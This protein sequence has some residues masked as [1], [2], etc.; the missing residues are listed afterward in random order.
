MIIENKILD[1][2][3]YEQK[4]WVDIYERHIGKRYRSAVGGGPRLI[5]LKSHKKLVT[6]C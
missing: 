6:M 5:R 3:R 1:G 4:L 2:K